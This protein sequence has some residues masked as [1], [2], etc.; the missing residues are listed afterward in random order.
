MFCIITGVEGPMPPQ[1]ITE[2]V[3]TLRKGHVDLTIH[4]EPPRYS[5]IPVW[6]YKVY[7]YIISLSNI[8][9]TE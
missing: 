5:D 8:T 6:K 1:N 9:V 3:T 7:M 4:W 2:G